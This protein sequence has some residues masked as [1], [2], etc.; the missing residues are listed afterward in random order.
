MSS[1]RPDTVTI[2]FRT[3]WL[4]LVLG[5]VLVL[6][7]ITPIASSFLPSQGTSTPSPGSSNGSSGPAPNCAN[8][9]TIIIANSAFG[10]GQTVVVRAG[11][12]VTWVNKD[13]T[14]HT[15]TSD[16]GVWD[17]GIMNTGKSF[18]FTFSSP[19]TFPYHCNVHPMVGTIQVVP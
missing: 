14:Q 6:V 15:T 12:T 8:P 19:G 9:C 2:T 18:S 13:N 17:S 7:T 4:W 1:P 10:N 16:T 5:L 3:K 11:T